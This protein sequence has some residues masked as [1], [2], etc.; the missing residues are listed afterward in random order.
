MNHWHQDLGWHCQ[1]TTK[2]SQIDLALDNKEVTLQQVWLTCRMYGVVMLPVNHNTT[3]KSV[4]FTK[5]GKKNTLKQKSPV[6]LIK[7]TFLLWG[8]FLDNFLQMGWRRELANKLLLGKNVSQGEESISSVQQSLGSATYVLNLTHSR[9]LHP[10]RHLIQ[11]AFN[12]I[13]ASKPTDSSK[14]PLRQRPPMAALVTISTFT[15]RRSPLNKIHL[16]KQ[17]E[18]RHATAWS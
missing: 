8:V 15:M 13:S 1:Q 10:Y 3:S 12:L 18:G 5:T 6:S 11:T 2:L 14:K 16:S 17:A 4:S 9:F 7:A